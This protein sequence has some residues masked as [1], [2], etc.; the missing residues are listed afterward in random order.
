MLNESSD[1]VLVKSQHL[2]KLGIFNGVACGVKNCLNSTLYI[3]ELI[4]LI[5]H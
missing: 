1:V 2:C 5:I 4:D 3:F